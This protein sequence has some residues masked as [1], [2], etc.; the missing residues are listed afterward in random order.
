MDQTEI[1]DVYFQLTAPKPS[2]GEEVYQGGR[3]HWP[4]LLNQIFVGIP[5]EEAKSF[6]KLADDEWS[7]DEE[8]GEYDIQFPKG[9][10]LT[11]PDYPE[12][13]AH[14]YSITDASFKV[15]FNPP[16]I[17]GN[18]NPCRRPYLHDYGEH[19]RG[20][21]FHYN[22][23]WRNSGKRAADNFGCVSFGIDSFFLT[24]AT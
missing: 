9:S 2:P 8:K 12:Y 19:L 13:P 24:R 21:A 17:Q 7:K 23:G 5:G 11:V 4:L 15:R 22:Q 6:Q 20:E 16:I 14:G 10:V 1:Y 18:R 3:I